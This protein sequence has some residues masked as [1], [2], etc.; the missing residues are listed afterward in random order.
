MLE[1]LLESLGLAGSLASIRAVAPTGGE[2]AANPAAAHDV[3]AGAALAA[4]REDGA[5]AVILGGAGLVGI[6][7]AIRE[8]IPV[9]VLCSVESGFRGA[10]A[11]LDGATPRGAGAATLPPVETVGLSPALAAPARRWRIGLMPT[12]SCGSVMRNR[13][14]CVPVAASGMKPWPQGPSVVLEDQIH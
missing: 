2:I 10:F 7:G 5:E 14:T 8:R 12:R 4:A 6:A 3:L 13:P 11:M 1:E 9:P